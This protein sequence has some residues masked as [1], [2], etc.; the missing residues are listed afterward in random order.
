MAFATWWRGDQLPVLTR[1]EGFFAGPTE[2]AA[3]L[4]RLA[5]LEVA[6]VQRRLDEGHHAYIA[7]LKGQAVAYGWVATQTAHVGELDLTI[8]LLAPNGAAAAQHGAPR[9]ADRYLWDFATLPDWRGRG[10]YPRLLQ[11]ILTTEQKNAERFWIIAAPE[12]RASSAGISKAGFASVAHLSFQAAGQAGLV[13]IGSGERI[14]AAATLLQ[15]P[16]LQ[17]DPRFA[18]TPC[19]HCAIDARAEGREVTEVPCWPIP[20]DLIATTCHCA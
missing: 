15:V 2:D 19:W 13:A 6:E 5:R 7:W 20:G 8:S 11:A 10:I 4:A 12:N 14:G 18:L 9:G 17:A 3:L 1:I 16:V